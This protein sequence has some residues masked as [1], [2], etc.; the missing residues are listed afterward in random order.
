MV[1]AINYQQLLQ[2][3]KLAGRDPKLDSAQQFSMAV[4]MLFDWG[5]GIRGSQ[6]KGLRRE[7][8]IEGQMGQGI[9]C[10]APRQKVRIGAKVVMDSHTVAPDAERAIRGVLA[11]KESGDYIAPFYPLQ[12][13]SEYVKQA[14]TVFG[15][16]K[17]FKW[18]GTHS[19]RHGSAEQAFASG[20]LDAVKARIANTADE[21]AKRYSGSYRAKKKNKKKCV[22][23]TTAERTTKATAKKRRTASKK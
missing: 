9:L 2:L 10:V 22:K 11:G 6:V 1:G 8:F 17:Q 3:M 20:G 14:A 16:D 19:L 18:G 21:S 5:F 15:W 4:G 23:A 13:V 7:H 12:K